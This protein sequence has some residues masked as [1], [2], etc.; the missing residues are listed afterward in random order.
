MR[1]RCQEGRIEEEVLYTP[2]F[3]AELPQLKGSVRVEGY[4]H[5][6]RKGH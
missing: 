1:V 6:W 5:S 4:E 3:V 2:G